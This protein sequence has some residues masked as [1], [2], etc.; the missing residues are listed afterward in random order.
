[1]K[2]I[3]IIIFT[4]LLCLIN[5]FA[6]CN[7]S[8]AS[9]YRW[10]VNGEDLFKGKSNKLG[11]VTWEDDANYNGGVLTLNNYNGGQLKI[12][13]YGSCSANQTFAIKL[14]GENKITVENG[15]GIIADLPI[16]FI[17]D[18]K[19]T[20]NASVPIGSSYIT[21]SDNTITEI[22]DIK[23]DLQTTV[24][25]EPN[26][27][28]KVDDNQVEDNTGSEVV[29]PDNSN[30]MDD[31]QI[32]NEESSDVINDS[33][34]QTEHITNKETGEE[35]DIFDNSLVKITILIYCIISI[36]VIFV[37]SLKLVNKK[38]VNDKYDL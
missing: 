29:N 37:L 9:P 5:S 35:N 16:V 8:A 26:N 18:G 27:S 17:G 22:D 33:E 10:T 3:N 13:C 7:V 14:I 12:G 30:E 1:M 23:W 6:L 31:T 25:I 4:V 11:N 21:N 34:D 19:I 32:E 24:T 20:I 36:A 38:Y 28:N 2:K 15:A